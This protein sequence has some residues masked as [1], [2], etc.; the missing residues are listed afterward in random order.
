MADLDESNEYQEEIDLKEDDRSSDGVLILTSL[1]PNDPEDPRNFSF[2][3][4]VYHTIILSCM[5]LASTFS[6][7][8]FSPSAVEISHKYHVSSEISTLS[9]A[10]PS[11]CRIRHRTSNLCCNQRGIR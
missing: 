8:I 5:S 1:E 11:A 6:S 2:G 4:K 9:T 3:R 10:R 7:S